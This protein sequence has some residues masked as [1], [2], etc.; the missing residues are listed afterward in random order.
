MATNRLV[1]QLVVML[2][3]TMT[4]TLAGRSFRLSAIAPRTRAGQ[5]PYF[6]IVLERIDQLTA[7]VNDLQASVDE[8]QETVTIIN[9]TVN[10]P[11][12]SELTNIL[13]FR[14]ALSR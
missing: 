8:I 7:L 11:V 6:R 12:V 10:P 5:P 9:A 14:L 1:L 3:V 2:T 13:S 4:T